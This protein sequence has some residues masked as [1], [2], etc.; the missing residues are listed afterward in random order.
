MERELQVLL[1][2]EHYVDTPLENF[3]KAHAS[4]LT[5]LEQCAGH[6]LSV[7]ASSA[8][9]EWVFSFAGLAMTKKCTTM[10]PTML[11]QL[12]FLH[13]ARIMLGDDLAKN[14]MGRK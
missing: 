4:L 12:S 13:S 14:A 1:K 8:S 9:S 11:E 3:W 2:A 10:L 7:Q 5:I 6:Y